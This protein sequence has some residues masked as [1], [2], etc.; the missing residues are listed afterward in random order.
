M[1]SP[2]QVEHLV[3]VGPDW[4]SCLCWDG[5]A[6]VTDAKAKE[7]GVLHAAVYGAQPVT[8][9]WSWADVR[10]VGTPEAVHRWLWEQSAI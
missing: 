3:M 6:M 9:E 2:P 5:E 10:E 7:V 4:W 8:T 1:Y